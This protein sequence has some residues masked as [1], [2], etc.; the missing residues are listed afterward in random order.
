[1]STPERPRRH[2]PALATCLG[3][4]AIA[5]LAVL[6]ALGNWPLVARSAPLNEARAALRS[7]RP[8]AVAQQGDP[9][10]GLGREPTAEEIR[11][12]DI[13]VR[14]DGQGLPPGRGSVAHGAEV[15][16]TMC[17][18]CH[19]ASGEGGPYDRL[20]GRE[21]LTSPSPVKTIGNYWPYAAPLWD[22]VR[23]AMPFD[24]PGSLAPDDV[25]AVVAW[26]LYMNEIVPED[27]VL[28]RETLPQVR[29]PAEGIFVP[30]PRPDVP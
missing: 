9:T 7:D 20:V 13:D 17:A 1:M 18:I 30:D 8:A 14:P 19:G 12:W 28:D 11:R 23:R 6:A 15:Y 25:Y 26:L 3:G 16:A 5:S 22:Y 29:M 24:R 4:L 27:A 2:A 10:L 21:P